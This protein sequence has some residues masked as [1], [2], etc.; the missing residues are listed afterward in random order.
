VHF[1]AKYG[2]PITV[3]VLELLY[4]L[5]SGPP[6]YLRYSGIVASLVIILSIY[7]NNNRIEVFARDTYGH[8]KIRIDK[9]VL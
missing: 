3:S 6:L 2:G 8:T 5:A 7:Y 1:C 9:E 4:S